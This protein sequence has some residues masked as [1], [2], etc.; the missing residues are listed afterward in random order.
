MEEI[1]NLISTLSPIE[2][3]VLPYLELKDESKIVK[4]SK[5]D[6]AKVKRALAYLD[7]KKII[8]MKFESKKMVVLGN[9][10]VLYI[11]NELPERRLLNALAKK[12]QLSMQD[13]KK[14]ANLS[15]NEVS[16]ALGALKKK[17][18][19]DFQKGKMIL[20]ASAKEISKLFLEEIF[21]KILPIE[22]NKLT[23]EQ[24]FAL[25]SLKKRKEVVKIEEVKQLSYEITSS[26]KKLLKNLS[27][28]KA[29]SKNTIETLNSEM[30]KSGSWKGK[31]FR[32]YDI[33]TGVPKISGGKRHFMNQSIKYA[34]RIWMD[35]GFKEM[36]GN[37]INTSFWDFDS[38]F[39]PQDHPAREMQDTFFLKEKGKLP[40]KKLVQT[41]KAA[42]EN[43]T[44]G[45]KGWRYI[46][47]EEE[48]KRLVLR[49]HTTV[50]S[51]QTLAKLKKK[52]WPA[53]FFALGRVYRN[54]TIDWKHAFEFNQTEG[55]VIDPNATFRDLL[56][57]L[58][59]FFAK[60]GYSQARFRP[61]YFPYTEPSI[62]I[63]V[64]HPVKKEWVEIGG[65]G[66]FRPELTE[67]LL[68]E[69][70]PVLAW[71][72]G[73]DR[74]IMEYHKIKDLREI[75]SNEIGKLRNIKFWM[76]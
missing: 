16:V 75:Y 71:G 2:R 60:M 61:S 64:Y 48:A 21:L 29:Y 10:G 6:S 14:T 52:D 68:G 70:V 4:E 23:P 27:K 59:Q 62:E 32:H 35:M 44:K 36:E 19:I 54:E 58:K 66:I 5:M 69:A 53:K 72:P 76:K 39:V 43:G 26:G 7:S 30:L 13:A 45:S 22:E 46:W 57:Y 55:I 24:K 38:L 25:E 40:D 47:S 37:V 3:E 8:Q 12:K 28:V 18:L 63:D 65:A 9:N 42:H 73:F 67:P 41:V 17:A 50:L 15:D 51:S 33:K 31:K 1:D 11:K 49:T 20:N 56:G 74:I 34:R